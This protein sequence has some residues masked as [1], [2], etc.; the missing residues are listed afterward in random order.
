[1]K[2]II[3]ELIKEMIIYA[4]DKLS[5]ED[6]NY[7]LKADEAMG[8]FSELGP[9]LR[10]IKRWMDPFYDSAYK[11]NIK[12]LSL[13][14][15]GVDNEYVYKKYIQIFEYLPEIKEFLVLNE[16][17]ITY[18]PDLTEDELLEMR[19]YVFDN[20]KRRGE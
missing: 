1:M 4:P 3:K 14:T 18:N 15:D 6:C 9:Y 20:T 5:L 17:S 2:P 7:I 8:G 16:G 11:T 19:E 10:L 13:I 12:E